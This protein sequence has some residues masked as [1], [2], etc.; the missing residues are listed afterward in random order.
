MDRIVQSP[1][2]AGT[3]TARWAPLLTPPPPPRPMTEAVATFRGPVRC[4]PGA[5]LLG[6]T[7]VGELAETPGEPA[8]LAFSAPSGPVLPEQLSDLRVERVEPGRYRLAS[9]T[10]EWFLSASAVHLQRDVGA[11]FYGAIPPRHVPWKKRVFWRVVL[12]LAGSRR[13]LELLRRLRR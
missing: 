4:L 8:L 6:L 13:G 11:A 10:R 9:G 1:R 7:L 12:A 5:Q 3:N 2:C